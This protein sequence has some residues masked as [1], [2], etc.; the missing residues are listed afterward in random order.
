MEKMG[1]RPPPKNRNYLPTDIPLLN[2]KN[3]PVP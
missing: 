2:K 1:K 3:S